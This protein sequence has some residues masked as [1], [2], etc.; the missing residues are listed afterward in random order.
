MSES[1]LQA[2]REWQQRER[3]SLY[4]VREYMKKN[5]PAAEPSNL[6]I[7]LMVVEVEMHHLVF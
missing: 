3:M 6:A 7:Q 4:R 5:G 2:Q 1:L